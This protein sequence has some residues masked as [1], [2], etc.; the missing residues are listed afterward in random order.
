MREFPKLFLL[1]LSFLVLLFGCSKDFDDYYARPSSLA[2]PIYQQLEARGNF[3]SLLK[4]IDK[5][6]YT[7]T[8]SSGGYWTLLAPNDDAFK[9]YLSEKGYSS[10]DDI[11]KT[12]ASN[13]VRYLLIY[14]AYDTAT[15]DNYQNGTGDD[16]N[17]A[18]RRKT[19]YYK[20]VYSDTTNGTVRLVVDRVNNSSTLTYTDNNYKYIPFITTNYFNT[21]SVKTSDYS[22]FYPDASITDFNV[23]G[24]NGVGGS[25]FAENGYYIEINKVIEPLPNIYEYIKS[26]SSY[27]VFKSLLDRFATFTVDD[28][29]QSRYLQASGS[30]ETVYHK[31]FNDTLAF[32]P[33]GESYIANSNDAQTDCWSI[34]V[35]NND[36]VNEYVKNVLGEYYDKDISKVPNY[37]I[38][39]FINSHMW[40]TSVWP[41][42]FNSA[43]TALSEFVTLDVNSDV[44][45]KQILSNGMFYGTDK[46]YES[47]S[48]TSVYAQ[49]FL[50]PDYAFMRR[51]IASNNYKTMLRN[52]N[53]NYTIFMVKDSA[54]ASD[55]FTYNN[56]YS[57]WWYN[58]SA[59]ISNEL[60]ATA[61][62]KVTRDFNM[63]IVSSTITDAQSAEG[64]AETYG[65]EC[66]YYNNGVVYGSGNV[67][68]S[69]VANITGY[70][71]YDNGRV[72]FIDKMLKYGQY[73]LYGKLRIL[74]G[75]NPKTATWGT[76][77][78]Y[79]PFFKLIEASSLLTV[80]SGDTAHATITGVSTG[81]Y[82]TMLVPNKA[83]IALALATNDSS[84]AS[85]IHPYLYAYSN[86]SYNTSDINKNFIKYHFLNK[87]VVPDGN[88]DKLG[89][90]NTA[91]KDLDGNV[92]TA[93]VTNVTGGVTVQGY[94]TTTSA[95]LISGSS[96]QLASKAVIHLVSG[97]ISYE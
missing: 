36:A 77:T 75:Y 50:N 46:V 27:S 8:L 3:T 71:D 78:E 5:A 72:Y 20:W 28:D 85:N 63:Q 7:Y 56:D 83:S 87:I 51:L 84:D 24:G 44:V 89:K 68:S 64:V 43:Y 94:K 16:N 10:V 53:L 61:T 59:S 60:V 52:S 82:Y 96:N 37:I 39:E 33:N 95:T 2:D 55:L 41:S 12:T 13:I 19:G 35:P 86:T 42:S 91:A 70:R 54:Y 25:I 31:Y 90:V 62:E 97:F 18:F 79:Y 80:T 81:D 29:F 45:D 9:T 38:A 15:I 57:T 26:K 92:R 40:A 34:I 6:N 32:S 66:I 73:S 23:C 14:N 47:R 65:G 49:P 4:L 88:T 1:C 67:D 22:Y 48:F 76:K 11:D 69:E 93:T 30:S 58:G 17:L 74:A 21:S